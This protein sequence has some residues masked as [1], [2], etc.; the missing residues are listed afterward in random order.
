MGSMY[1]TPYSHSSSTKLM[2]YNS[3]GNEKTESTNWNDSQ[4][5]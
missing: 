1:A 4:I 5:S 2:R 3:N